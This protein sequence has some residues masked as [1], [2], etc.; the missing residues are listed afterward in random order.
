M[1]FGV[2]GAVHQRGLTV[3]RG[4]DLRVAGHDDQ[5]LSSFTCPPLTTVAQ[6]I[7]E[8]GRR[9]LDLVFL[10]MAVEDG[11][12]EIE[13]GTDRILLS[14]ELVL[15]ARREGRWD[16]AVAIAPSSSCEGRGAL[17]LQNR[18]GPRRRTIHDGGPGLDDGDVRPSRQRRRPATFVDGPPARTK[19]LKSGADWNSGRSAR[20]HPRRRSLIPSPVASTPIAA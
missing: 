15:R 18:P 12:A 6:D 10:K 9:A 14:A 19:P 5:P 20:H 4:L 7:R 1:A 13:P 16:M 8:I 3:G 17:M 2:L 11:T